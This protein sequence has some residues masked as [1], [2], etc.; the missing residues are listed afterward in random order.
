[1]ARPS[2]QFRGVREAA[3]ARRSRAHA[4]GWVL[5]GLLAG[6]VGGFVAGLLR[7]PARKDVSGTS[8]D[9]APSGGAA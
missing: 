9:D 7:S 1:M 3:V 4:L 2:R 8:E 5:V 6:V